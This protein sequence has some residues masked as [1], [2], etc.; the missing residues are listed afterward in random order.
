MSSSDLQ[1]KRKAIQIIELERKKLLD[2]LADD[3]QMIEGSL[4]D[5]LVKCGREGCHCEK[6]PVHMVTRLTTREK[7]QIK[8][9]V[10]RVD[11]REEVRHLVQA[12]KQFKRALRELGDLELRQKKILKTLKKARNKIY[13]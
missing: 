8:L 9:R 7:G 10:V 3:G 2:D 5:I 4:S 13:T 12:H 11:D 1:Q 6:K